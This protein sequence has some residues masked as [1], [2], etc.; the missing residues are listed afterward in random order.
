MS[1]YGETLDNA[2]RFFLSFS[3]DCLKTTAEILWMNFLELQLLPEN[4]S[5][6]TQLTIDHT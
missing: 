4:F 2:L 1:I 3:P 5:G 6:D